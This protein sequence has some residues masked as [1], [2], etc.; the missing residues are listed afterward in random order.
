MTAATDVVLPGSPDEAISA[1][2]DGIGVT[3]V[4]GG[5]IV[6]PDITAGRLRPGKAMLLARAGLAGVAHDGPKVT[7]GAM[8]T[9]QSLVDLAAPVGPCAANVADLEVRT[10]RRSAATSAQAKARTRRAEI[11][12]ARSS[13]SAHTFARPARA[14]SPPK[15]LEDFLGHRDER[16]ILDVSYE[17]PASGA[18]VAIDRP[19]THEYTTMAVSAAKLADGSIR[20]AATGAGWWGVRL[21]SAEAAAADPD[22]AGAAALNDVQ[23][24]DDALASAW[25]REQALPVLVKRAL[26]RL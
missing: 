11:S 9:L 8:T 13:P 20:L 15:P 4:G 24:H 5:T 19:H 17:E 21:P 26:A 14:E 6:M 25:Y 23:L 12:R 18:F 10:R 1:F 2:G 22:K 3:V 7:L 16:L